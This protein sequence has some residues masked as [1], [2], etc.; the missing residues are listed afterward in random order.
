MTPKLEKNGSDDARRFEHLV[1]SVTDYAIYM[2]DL[3]GFITSWN[4][5]ANKVKGY[6]DAEIIGE[7]F[8]LFFTPEDRERG[9]PRHILKEARLHGRFE[10]EGWRVRKDGARFWANAVVDSIYDETGTLIG[11]A[12]ITR[13]LTERKAAQDALL[14][15][16]SR[17]R[18]LVDAVIDYAIYMLDPSG[19]ITNWNTG[20]ERLKGYTANEIIGSHFS[21]FYSKEDRAAG[22]PA[23]VLETARREG[24][25]EAEG[26]RV[27]KDGSRFWASVVIDAIKDDEGNLIG[28]AKITRDMTERQAAQETLRESERQFRLL[29]RGVSDYALYM[30]DPQ[31]I[32]TNWN[33]GAE[34]IKG[35]AAED[36]VGQHFSRFYTETDRRNGMPARALRTARTEGRFEAEGWRV[37]KDGTMF[38]AN[39]IIDPIKDDDGKLIGFAKITR[40][41]TER[42]NAELALQKA[43]AERDH[44]QRLEALGKL[45]G[46]VAHDFNNL[47]MIVSG[48]LETLKRQRLENP[49]AQRALDAIEQ[50]ASRAESLTRQLLTFSRRQTLNPESLSITER[51]DSLRTLIESS[52]GSS[53]KLV[54]QIP[55]D[56]WPVRV[57]PNEFE[58]ALVNI[59]I[60]ARDAMPKGGVITLSAGNVV[61]PDGDAT[62]GYEGDYV[63]ISIS[64]TGSGIAPD[65]LEKVFDPFFTTKEVG[66]GTG[67]GLSQVHGFAHQ[68]GGT[69]VVRSRLGTGTTIK[70][71]LPRS[72]ENKGAAEDDSECVSVRSGITLIVEDNPEVAV[73]T[74]VLVEQLGYKP[75]VAANA[76]AAL[77]QL[78]RGG[79]DLVVS[80][81]VMAGEMDGIQLAQKIRQNEPSIP[82][83][84]VTGYAEQ[85]GAAEN[86]FTVLRKPYRLVDLNRAISKSIVE[87]E[88]ALAPN[89]VKLHKVRRAEGAGEG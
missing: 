11:F 38:W 48:H 70:F 76:S 15:S 41:I 89:V 53:V 79:V 86:T 61:L 65:I 28:F 83:V 74:S 32:I 75:V 20:A 39:V 68:S 88:G 49:K 7:H 17:F 4:A 34:R 47:L 72:E 58:L 77:Q 21:Q 67:L 55:P 24:R 29:V 85:L 5:G 25:Y 87:A 45:T 3:D 52:I 33:S 82:I 12:K 31:G 14:A 26:W 22:Q 13:D 64:D 8:S 40:D 51:L 16:E 60:N 62:R 71:Y 73:A 63:A 54:M 19:I 80:D 42:R 10:S 36:V 84:L 1:R 35:Y 78:A 69:V 56:L 23:V 50:A 46:G 27:R 9:L 37:R 44:A 81:I 57:D 2:L 43:Q 30:L 18:L 6:T 59:V 66:K